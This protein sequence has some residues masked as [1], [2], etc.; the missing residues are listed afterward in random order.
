[1]KKTLGYFYKRTDE[2]IAQALQIYGSF[3]LASSEKE[4]LK[5]IQRTK[6]TGAI[7]E[8]EKPKVFRVTVEEV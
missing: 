8:R 1:M 3:C 5:D 6:K 4:I 2:S 7:S